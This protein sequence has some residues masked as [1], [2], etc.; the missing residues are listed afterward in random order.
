MRD[1]S[2]NPRT[3]LGRMLTFRR[4]KGGRGTPEGSNRVVAEGEVADEKWENSWSVESNVEEG[5][6]TPLQHSC[7]ENPMDRGAW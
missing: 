6:G 5:N 7:L 3:G 4:M 1:R 2:S